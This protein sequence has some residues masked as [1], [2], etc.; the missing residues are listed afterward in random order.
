MTFLYN[1]S[2]RY[3][4]NKIYIIKQM[5]KSEPYFHITHVHVFESPPRAKI[6]L[7]SVI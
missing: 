4:I 3:I 5:F 1:K 2:Y 6:S 7:S